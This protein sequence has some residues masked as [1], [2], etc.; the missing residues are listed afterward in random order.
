MNEPLITIDLPTLYYRAFHA[1]PTTMTAP[2]GTP[3][4]AIRGTLD[5]LATLAQDLGTRRLAAV[6]DA[7]WRP[8]WR[9]AILPE[10]KAERAGETGSEIPPE[11]APQI[12][13]LQALLNAAG[14]TS[15]EVP[16]TEADDVIGSMVGQAAEPV[17]IVST[18][19]DL[20]SLLEPGHDTVLYRPK[21][22]GVW[23]TITA[24]DLPALY[25]VDSGTAYR[26]LAALR[27]DPSD[28]IAGVPGIGE[29]TAAKL[30]SGY[31]DLREVLAAAAAGQ[32]SHGLS[33]RR[34]AALLEA[35]DRIWKNI[36]VMTIRQDLDVAEAL[37]APGTHSPDV[38]E[39]TEMADE[40]G[41][42]RSAQRLL[43]ALRA[44]IPTTT[45]GFVPARPSTP[46]RPSDPQPL[47]WTVGP[48]FA[49][50]LETT[51]VDPDTARV[52]TAALI[53]C[54]GG[55][56]GAQTTWLVDPGVEI[57]ADA[58]AIH[59]ISTETARANGQPAPAALTQILA[60]LEQVRAAGGAVVGHNLVYDL[61]VLQREASRYGLHPDAHAVCPWVID[62]LVIDKQAERYRR[63]KRTLT[64]TAQRWGVDLT[65]AH[66]AGADARA[67]AGIAFAIAAEYPDFRMSAEALHAAQIEWKAAQAKD[68]ESFLRSKGRD[69]HIDG[70][71]P[72]ED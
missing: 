59:G 7:D 53:D 40:L 25:G 67:S 47:P 19:R 39:L 22:K 55:E 64:A 4:N 56:A 5:A 6:F 18:D 61:T 60:A 3:V 65:D 33:A 13:M 71:W 36:E 52:V 62:T 24:A 12:P 45:G 23:E 70:R 32:R 34:A 29:K 8:A 26:E 31:G 16:G 44:D 43:T 69:A 30:L 48:V 28:G 35:A 20:L 50:D 72:F 1:L 38:A 15:A 41:L 63:G 58:Q 54:T 37:R 17:T 21:P 9:T 66:D 27:G 51:G 11:L 10:Y 46:A 68:F 42:G 49:F 14:I 57:P 2:D